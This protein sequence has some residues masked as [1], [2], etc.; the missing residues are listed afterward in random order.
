MSEAGRPLS[1]LK[2]LRRYTTSLTDDD[3]SVRPGI[4]GCHKGRFS[5][6]NILNA[7]PGYTYFHA[8][9]TEADVTEKLVEGWEIVDP[10]KGHPERLAGAG[11]GELPFGRHQGKTADGG[12]SATHEHILMRIHKD[13]LREL[14]E[15]KAQR[16]RARLEDADAE[17]LDKGNQL[18]QRVGPAAAP[19]RGPLYYRHSGHGFESR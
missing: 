4:M 16:N 11:I 9:K 10:K 2:P 18:Q 8:R 6:F 19:N 3:P 5:N 15:R 17:F 1:L 13:A 14:A 7:V 12:L